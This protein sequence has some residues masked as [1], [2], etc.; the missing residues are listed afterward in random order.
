M[1]NSAKI[2]PEATDL[3]RRV[4]AHEQILQS[5]SAYM[6]RS[7]P[8]FLDY[9][10]KTFV[11]PMDMARREHDFTDTDSY[12]KDFVRAAA[13]LNDAHPQEA[14][15]IKDEKD[16]IQ[17]RT[18]AAPDGLTRAPWEDRVKTTFRNGIWTVVVDGEFAGDYSTRET[19]ETAAAQVRDPRK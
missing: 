15:V 13:A 16:H 6:S 10:A 18:H 2:K 12:A 9:L 11:E 1:T 17:L 14:D 3:E 5:L 8:R 4:L 7:E 19:A